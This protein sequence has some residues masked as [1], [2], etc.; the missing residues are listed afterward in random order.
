MLEPTYD[1][2]RAIVSGEADI[3]LEWG[4]RGPDGSACCCSTDPG[5]IEM[6]RAHHPDGV[7]VRTV[8]VGPWQKVER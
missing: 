4:G 1:E 8:I 3:H 2:L 6:L 7:G 5:D